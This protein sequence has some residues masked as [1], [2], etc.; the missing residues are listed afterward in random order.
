FPE[1]SIQYIANLLCYT[2]MNTFYREF[3]KYKGMTPDEYRKKE[4]SQQD[5][6]IMPN[7]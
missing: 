6:F 2:S 3:K 4:I 7:Q 5:T 1:L